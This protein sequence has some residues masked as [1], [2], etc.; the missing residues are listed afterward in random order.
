[1]KTRYLF[2]IILFFVIS[3]NES[4]SQ[5]LV[6]SDE[7][8]YNGLPDASKWGNEIGYIRNNE[9]QYYTDRDI[10]NQ[11][12]RNGC[13]EIIGLEE[14][15]GG[16]NYTSASIN[17]KASFSFTYGTIEARMKLPS[18]QGLW[19]AFWML[20]ANID[21][22]GWPACGEID[23]MEHVNSDDYISGTAHWSSSKGNR[24]MQDQGYSTIDVTQ[25]HTYSV[26]WDEISIKWFVDGIQYH[27]LSILNAPDGMAELHMPQY[28]LLNLAI[29]GDW[30]GA[31]DASTVFPA[32]MY[33][34]YVRV[35]QNDT[36]EPPVTDNLIINPGFED[37]GLN[38]APWTSWGNVSVV[39]NNSY[40]GTNC[41][42][43]N[44]SGAAEQVVTLDANT[45]YTLSGF[46]KVASRRQSVLLGIKEYGGA[47]TSV[48][49]DQTSYS[50]K[51][52]QFTTGS[53]NTS[54][55]IF[56]YVAGSRNAA[57][58]DDFS[59]TLDALKSGMVRLNKN[60]GI[61][62]FELEVYPNP[63]NGSNLKV[64]LKGDFIGAKIQVF[65]VQGKELFNTSINQNNTTI[66]R[67]VFNKQGLFFVRVESNNGV[68]VKKIL[69]K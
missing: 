17:T 11:I 36:T 58:G 67:T 1:M 7:F 61:D 52:L 42:Y 50:Q 69:V 41:V 56:F 40:S 15:F 23:I 3:V 60:D 53:T 57:Y 45:T 14:S 48:T 33:V 20:G 43:V 10:D 2:C 9:L 54:A 31:P 44:G 13:L 66:D 5:T 18:G 35:Y 39:S 62:K 22:V 47:E 55:K 59:I 26:V 46:A 34:D 51:S 29:G 24:H 16:Y 12:V 27:Q 19:P 30:P 6:W 64:N 21:Q 32:T 28:I 4:K 63:L 38:L 49:F 37:A 8:D 65:N 25:W 68:I